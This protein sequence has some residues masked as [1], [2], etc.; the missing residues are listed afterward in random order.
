MRLRSPIALVGIAALGGTVLAA[1]P[2]WGATA[3]AKALVTEAIAA[4]ESAQTVR[5]SGT[6]SEGKEKVT[7]NVQAS[8]AAK[9]QGSIG[10]NGA[11]ANVIRLGSRVYFSA[12][13]AFWTEN[14][15]AAAASLFDGK[16]VFTTAT[17][18]DGQSLAEFLDLTSLMH[19][20]FGANL[21][22]ATFTL[23][24]NTTINGVA[25]VTINGANTGGASEGTLYVA[26]TGKPYVIELKS[27]GSS[28]GSGS[29]HFSAYNQSVNP[30]A[31]KN[32]I[33]LNQLNQA[34]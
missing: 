18:S 1:T 26:R 10:I 20:M 31:P 29:L 5:V 33:N 8:N 28:N 13:K 4:S 24:K 25:V 22:S 27:T 6:V 7:L 14:G 17:S 3:K 19:Q 30:V 11:V 23:G 32:P 12:D 9:G 21:G 34:G 2:A 15:G 16:W